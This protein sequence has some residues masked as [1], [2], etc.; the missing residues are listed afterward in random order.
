[1]KRLFTL[2][3]SIVLGL[4][5]LMAVGCNNTEYSYW[6]ITKLVAD[7]DPDDVA[8]QYIEV[9]LDSSDIKEVWIN[10]SSLSES[11]TT[12]GYV[13]GSSSSLKEVT[14]EKAFLNDS[15]GWYKISASGTSRTLKVTFIDTMRVNE[16]L[17]VDDDNKIMTFTFQCYVIRPDFTSDSKQ[18]F[19]EDELTEAGTEHNALCA[20][21]EQDQFDLTHLNEVFDSASELHADDEEDDT[22]SDSSAS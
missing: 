13:F 6:Q 4:V 12:I 9:Y 18:T 14:V 5:S 15:E 16:I 17:F 8:L 7:D 20:F 10:I 19:T 22:D 3:L 21:D 11:E 2:I 1:M